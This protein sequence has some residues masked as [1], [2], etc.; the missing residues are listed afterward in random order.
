[1]P[2]ESKVP[3][4]GMEA[5]SLTDVGLQ[6]SNNEDSYLYWE[7]DSESD[8]RRKGRLA[9]VAD[10]M[11]GYEGG[12]EA[13]RLAVETVRHIY[14][15]NFDNDPQQTL[16]T[17]FQSAHD[18]IQRYGMEHP[19]F[20]GMG[21]TCTAICIIDHQL[22]FAHVGDSRLYLVRGE[23]ITRLTR[24]HSYV[25][26]LVENGIVRSEDA[27]SHPQR[28]ILTAA[29]G[30]GRDVTPHVPQQPIALEESDTLILCTDGLWSLVAD[31][32]LAQ[33]AQSNSPAEACTRLVQMALARGGPDNITLVI[34][35]VSAL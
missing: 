18:N 13:S 35:R 24:D 3:K 20:H 26:R 34:L 16:I 27:E 23:T 31:R 1:M 9:V 15:R 29:L 17:A 19:Q 33:V 8:F 30:S 14:D 10:G 4:P 5:A 11:G 12:Q 2:V 25:G 28:H 32:D 21:T 7:P 6:R 22:R